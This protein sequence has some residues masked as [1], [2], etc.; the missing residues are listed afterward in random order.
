[1]SHVSIIDVE[2]TDLE[3]LKNACT[4]MG[5]IFTEGK[6]TYK[7]Y[8]Q[9]LEGYPLPEGFSKEDL[10]TCDHAVTVP[11]ANYEIG[12]VK[13]EKKYIL[14]WD[15]WSNGGLKPKIGDKGGLLIQAYG[16]E[17]TKLEAKRKGFRVSERYNQKTGQ[18]KL[19]IRLK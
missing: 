13:R 4:R 5:F 7:W 17:K 18:V 8:G 3:A 15:F 12:V 6:R 19:R 16:V 9:F 11:G 2:I 14:L 10:G 1:M